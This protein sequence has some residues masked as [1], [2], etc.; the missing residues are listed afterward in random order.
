MRPLNKES[1]GKSPSMRR[2]M[3]REKQYNKKVTIGLNC[4]FILKKL[5]QKQDKAVQSGHKT[6]QEVKTN[7][8][9]KAITYEK[10]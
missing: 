1:D 9:D 2:I 3:E 10:S 7:V 5:M 6:K 4:R 8:S